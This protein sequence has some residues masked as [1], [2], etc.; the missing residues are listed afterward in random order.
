MSNIKLLR[1]VIL[2][3]LAF[4]MLFSTAVAQDLVL[5]KGEIRIPKGQNRT[6]EFDLP[7]QKDAAILLDVLARLDSDRYGG[8]TYFMKIVLNGQVVGAAKSRT[9]MRITN[10]KLVS[11]VAPN[12]PADW[13]GNQAWR[14]LYA[15]DFEGALKFG[16][17]YE[18][19]PYRTVL[20]VTDLLNLTS[21]NRLEIFNTCKY[22]PPA[23]SKANYDL[24]IKNLAIR[25]RPGLSPMMTV[26]SADQGV[27]NRGTPGAGAS[28]Y[29][30][31][32]LP[33]GGFTLR[34]AD[35]SFNFSSRISYP[36]AGFNRLSSSN[37]PA[38]GGQARFLITT[39]SWAD[40]GG[41]QV[42]A[43][44]PDYRIIRTVRFTP[45]K[46]EV[47]DQ[48]T[49]LHRHAKLGLIFENGVNLDETRYKV[50]LAGIPDNA[51]NQYYSPGNP[52]VYAALPGNLGLGLLCE[53]DIYRNQATLFF[54][55]D[56]AIL[57][58][59]TD[60]LCL[61]AGG[62]YTL[63]WSVYPV[64]SHDYY[65]FINLVRQDWGSNYT[66]E[67][68]WTFF[69][70]DA[71]ISTPVEKIREQF[72]RMGIKRACCGGG[73][74]DRNRDPRR[75]GFGTGV[76]DDY[77]E[78]YRRRLRLAA[79][80]IRQAVPDCKVYVYYDTQR[81]TS[82]GG[83]ERF[84]DSWLTNEKG[85]QH[86]TEWGG[87][88][89]RTHSVVATHQNSFGKA[90]LTAVDRYLGELNINGLYWDEMEGVGYGEPLITYNVGDGYSCELDPESYTIK[91]EIGINTIMGEGHRLAVIKR[92]RE[93]GGDLMG[94]GP[95]TTRNILTLHPQRMVE[96]QNNDHYHYEGNLGSPLGYAGLRPDFGNW[97]RA[98]KMAVLLVGKQYNYTY[99]IQ[100]YVFPFTPVELHAG[101]LLGEERIITTHSGSYGW[102]GEKCLV[103]VRYFDVNGKLVD[104]DF[105]TR[106]SN[107]ARTDV[108][109]GQEEAAVL[110]RLPV[111]VTSAKV[112]VTIQGVK[113]SPEV[114][115]FSVDAH[116]GFSLELRTG[117][118]RVSPEQKFDVQVDNVIKMVQADKRGLLRIYFRETAVSQTVYVKPQSQGI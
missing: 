95:N 3:G 87:Q 97:V 57:G 91:R 80:K 101:Y 44:G 46:V 28:R 58:M 61:P 71:I 41:G 104:R 84:R 6:F 11:P 43:E 103:Q 76:L 50:R 2:A 65:D 59:R 29:T 15:P 118:M 21:G 73:W 102:P 92:V 49:N 60:K 31:T 42:T 62:S 114:L 37:K 36:N 16:H 34:F 107:E 55:T 86:W 66:V 19:N 116:K 72:T 112:P 100:R 63:R 33:G 68:A 115:N 1:G 81:D 18:D 13:F 117:E 53:D 22:N 17:Y 108:D 70:P 25:T 54:D 23:G 10:K 111:T 32:L 79:E 77:W 9:A 74:V 67:G 56:R 85:E 94:N 113:Y 38:S 51:I 4:W 96:I 69:N 26:S 64:A 39:K 88:Y 110:E 99:D 30:G 24:V 90:M 5:S 35:R 7:T 48:I 105:R 12:K 20:D 40:G 98:I 106:I 82:E 14:V 109:V 47:A 93:L 27:I 78:D 45:R 89:S 52:T 75:I 83:P 8:S